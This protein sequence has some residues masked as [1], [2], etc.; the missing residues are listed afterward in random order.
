VEELYRVRAAAHRLTDGGG[1]VQARKMIE[2]LAPP[3]VEAAKKQPRAH[4]N[5]VYLDGT[6]AKAINYG[7]DEHTGE[8]LNAEVVDDPP[9]E[10]AGPDSDDDGTVSW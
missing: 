2:N 6:T 4:G 10:G 8:V 9:V 1:P 5:D 7:V 3:D